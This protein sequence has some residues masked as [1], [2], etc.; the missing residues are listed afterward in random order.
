M[1]HEISFENGEQVRLA[2]N[3]VYSMHSGSCC[4]TLG[5]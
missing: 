5:L 2:S 3:G 4:R 1:I